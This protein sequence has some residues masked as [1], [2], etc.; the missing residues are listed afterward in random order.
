MR[1]QVR[2]RTRTVHAA[3][4]TV[5]L[6]ADG[7]S[8]KRAYMAFLY[9]SLTAHIELGI[10]AAI[11]RADGSQTTERARIIALR[12]DLGTSQ[13]AIVEQSITDQSFAWGVGYALNGSALGA[14]TILKHG[15]LQRDWPRRYLEMGRDYARTGGVRRFFDRLNGEQLDR[16]QVVAGALAVFEVFKEHSAQTERPHNSDRTEELARWDNP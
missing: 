4:D 6:A 5:W 13:P 14:T 12:Q 16:D 8:S 9:A 1:L 15:G 2:A 7:F 3:L 11:R 10:P